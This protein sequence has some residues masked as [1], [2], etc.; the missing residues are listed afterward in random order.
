MGERPVGDA[1]DV[2]V[3]GSGPAGLGATIAASRAGATVLFLAERPLSPEDGVPPSGRG[4]VTVRG[5][6]RV[7][8]LFPDLTVAATGD[9]ATWTVRPR[10]VIV[11]TGSTDRPC[12]IPS[13]HLPG[14]L[15][16][17]E[18]RAVLTSDEIVPGA[19]V[20]IVS[21]VPE[22]DA[23]LDLS[24]RTA[25]VT[26]VA[27]VA[28]IGAEIIGPDRVTAIRAGGETVACD[29]VIL[30]GGRQARF[31]LAQMAG[32]DVRSGPGGFV[33]VVDGDGRTT[34]AGL[35]V[36]GDAAGPCSEA[37][38]AREGRL[39]G[40]VAAGVGAGVID[41][42]RAALGRL[43][44]GGDRAMI[45]ATTPVPLAAATVLC[46]CEGILTGAIDGA[47]RAGAASVNDVKRRT[48]A[49][50]GA[51]QG[52]LCVPLMAGRL[53]AAGNAARAG[54]SGPAPAIAPMTARPP[55]LPVTVAEL[56]ALDPRM[57]PSPR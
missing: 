53:S 5:R 19:R 32:C 29:R 38:A 12:P 23:S 24:L 35:F 40:M 17:A 11:A 26:V 55:A 20:A 46:R 28:A 57:A 14:T 16:P 36:V 6:T 33:P 41:E 47:I 56:A 43:D 45:A 4:W 37:V 31:T 21:A 42:E 52:S 8:G 50:M 25:G 30:D 2:V 13:W 48:R 9:G 18:T 27:R 44:P 22:P 3:I 7:W 34:V 10:A 1:F 49:G 39:A 54:R 15:T 51:C